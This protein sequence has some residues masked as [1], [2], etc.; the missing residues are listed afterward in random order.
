MHC[1]KCKKTR[2]KFYTC[3]I[4]CTTSNNKIKIV[5]LC[6]D[7]FDLMMRDEINF[8]KKLTITDESQVLEIEMT[9]KKDVIDD[10]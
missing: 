6:K 3:D 2:G 8:M 10:F 1:I 7:C 9:D 4:L 5:N